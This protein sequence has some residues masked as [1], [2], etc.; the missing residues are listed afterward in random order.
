MKGMSLRVSQDGIKKKPIFFKMKF[1]IKCLI[2]F[3]KELSEKHRTERS[4]NT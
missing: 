3:P 4:L 1:S 2:E